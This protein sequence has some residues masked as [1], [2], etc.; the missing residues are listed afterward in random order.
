MKSPPWK[1]HL[2]P[3]WRP[4]AIG[5]TDA[6]IN[7]CASLNSEQLNGLSPAILQWRFS[8]CVRRNLSPPHWPLFPATWIRI[9]GLKNRESKPRCRQLHRFFPIKSS[10]E[11][12]PE[13]EANRCRFF[14][15]LSGW[16]IV[17]EQL[18]K[19]QMIS[20]WCL[21]RKETNCRTRMMK[22]A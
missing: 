13:T 9:S 10:S 3:F 8:S 14:W 18:D 6:E 17:S 4:L 16:I 22:M 12:I 11:C 5:K 19:L 20:R 2:E 7:Q 21:R 15:D 1:R